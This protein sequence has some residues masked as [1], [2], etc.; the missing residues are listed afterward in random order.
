[1]GV[2]L[3]R[4]AVPLGLSSLG[5]RC[6]VSASLHMSALFLCLSGMGFFCCT[7]APKYPPSTGW[8]SSPFLIKSLWTQSL[9]LLVQTLKREIL[10]PG[11]LPKGSHIWATCLSLVQADM[12]K[13]KKVL[14]NNNNKKWLPMLFLQQGL[15]EKVKNGHKS[16]SGRQSL[17]RHTRKMC[18]LHRDT[19]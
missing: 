15:V 7:Q 6:Y 19:L 11:C 3:R 8:L 5:L 2:P 18:L 12:N 13:E 10:F 1:M 9:C 16:Y 14:N 4:G 17:A